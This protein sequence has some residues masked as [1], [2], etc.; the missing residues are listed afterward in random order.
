VLD[1]DGDTVRTIT[2]RFAVSPLASFTFDADS[3]VPDGS[4]VVVKRSTDPVRINNS[5]V[6]V[7]AAGLADGTYRLVSDKTLFA[8]NGGTSQTVALESGESG[9]VELYGSSP[10]MAMND[11][12]LTLQTVGGMALC[13]TNLT[14]LWVEISMRCGQ[15]DPLSEDNMPG[16]ST[17][18]IRLGQQRLHG[19]HVIA[20]NVPNSA[21]SIGNVIEI[22]GAVHPADFVG[23]VLFA[24]DN[25][26]EYRADAGNNNLAIIITNCLKIVLTFPAMC[27]RL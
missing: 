24:R 26:A 17:N 21:W 11:A 23:A 16:I 18:N 12:T 5:T 20:T 22:K 6:S 9:G 7:Q 14:V 27:A 13:T 10:S 4:V 1:R 2:R 25:I 19:V 15:D 3:L 8:A